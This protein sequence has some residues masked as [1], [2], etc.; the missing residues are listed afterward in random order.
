MNNS[1]KKP[2]NQYAQYAG[3]GF[4]MAAVML[5]MIWGGY[6]LDEHFDK[7]PVF[8]ITLTLLSIPVALY[9]S[10]KDLLKKKK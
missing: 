1:K 3:M 7:K 8:T 2:L 5:L 10:L 9:L 6:K 4:T